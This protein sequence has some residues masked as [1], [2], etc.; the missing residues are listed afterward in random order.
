MPSNETPQRR[1]ELVQVKVSEDEKEQLLQ[2]A[3]ADGHHHYTA[4]CRDV[5][6]KRARTVNQRKKKR[7]R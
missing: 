4:W 6:L 3:F 7:N 5:L 2:A 1:R